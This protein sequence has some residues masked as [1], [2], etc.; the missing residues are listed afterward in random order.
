MKLL[1]RCKEGE[2]GDPSDDKI[3][4]L[5]SAL[6]G[7]AGAADGLLK[8]YS[9]AVEAYKAQLALNPNDPVASYH[10]G[11]AYLQSTPPQSLDGFW[12][13]ARA[14]DLKIQDADKVKDYLRKTIAIISGA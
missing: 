2:S 5:E 13:L 1:L 9:A 11:L 6:D 3:K 7:A 12:A 8:D 4:A 14:V 10:L